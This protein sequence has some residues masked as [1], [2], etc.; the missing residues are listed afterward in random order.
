MILDFTTA[1]ECFTPDFGRGTL[2]WR[3]RPLSH[4]VSA[5]AMRTWNTRFAGKLAFTSTEGTGYFTGMCF[6]KGCKLHRVLW[7]LHTGSWPAAELDH[8][9]QDRKNNAVCNLREVTHQEN[10]KNQSM[11][12]NNTSG[13]TGVFI[14]PGPRKYQAQ[15]R[16]NGKRVFDKC[17]HTLPEAEAALA[18]ARLAHGF[19]VNHG[20]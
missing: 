4:F 8:I 17:F 14:V 7:L 2:T 20:K 10:S 9:D 19:H 5:H 3:V 15:L 1:N 11:K 12:K 16:H 6:G 13:V 18:A